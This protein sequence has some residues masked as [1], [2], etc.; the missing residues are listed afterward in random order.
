MADRDV[1]PERRIELGGDRGALELRFCGR[2]H[3]AGDIVVWH[4]RSRTLYAGDLVDAE[5]ALYTGD[6][7]H[8][9][10]ASSTLDRVKAYRAEQLVGG[11][12]AVARG[13]EATDA[14]IEKTRSFLTGMIDEVGAVVRSGGMLTE[15]FDRDHA[16]LEPTFDR[17]AHL[18][19]LPALRRPAAVGRARRHR[20]AAGLDRRTRPAGLGR[21]AGRSMPNV[22]GIPVWRQQPATPSPGSPDAAPVVMIGGGPV[23]LTLALDSGGASIA[24]WSSTGSTS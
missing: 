18:Q 9:E 17:L 8:R 24:S 3:T 19:A 23:G 10:W 12:G 1:R 2:G 6:A 4:D 16:A 13:V 22:P 7:L 11:R 20:P 21:A 15:G 5:A 14:A